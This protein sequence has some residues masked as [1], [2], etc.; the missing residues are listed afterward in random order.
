MSQTHHSAKK[1]SSLWSWRRAQNWC[2]SMEILEVYAARSGY[3]VLRQ[4]GRLDL[5]AI[6]VDLG[7]NLVCL[8]VRCSLGFG[9]IVLVPLLNP[10]S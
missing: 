2:C 9:L 3:M 1:W 4:D 7:R 6:A 10:D 5:A 8:G